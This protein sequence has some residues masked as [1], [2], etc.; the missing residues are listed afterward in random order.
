VVVDELDVE[1]NLAGVFRFEAATLQLEHRV[2]VELA[3]IEEHVKEK[4]SVPLLILSSVPTNANP[5]GQF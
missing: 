4:L 3:V 5:F 2:A 1:I